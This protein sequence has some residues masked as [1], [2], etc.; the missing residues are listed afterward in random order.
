MELVTEIEESEDTT[1]S[2]EEDND[3]DS[4]THR[5]YLKLMKDRN[6]CLTMQ[7]QLI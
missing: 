3:D 4:K 1:L 7:P 6:Y 5:M 2:D